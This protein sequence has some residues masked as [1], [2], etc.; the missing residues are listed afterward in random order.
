[1]MSETATKIDGSFAQARPAPIVRRNI[2]LRSLLSRQAFN[3]FFAFRSYR[4]YLKTAHGKKRKPKTINSGIPECNMHS[5]FQTVTSVVVV[6]AAS[7]QE[8]PVASDRTTGCG[9]D[10]ND[11]G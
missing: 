4:K 5:G 7:V 8:T 6:V 2:P 3:S 10:F 11:C 1:M 9:R